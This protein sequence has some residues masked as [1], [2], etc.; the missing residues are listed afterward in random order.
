[1][2]DNGDPILNVIQLTL[3][4]HKVIGTVQ[5]EILSH[6]NRLTSLNNV[7]QIVL[8]ETLGIAIR[9]RPFTH[10]KIKL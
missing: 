5:M 4:M 8:L 7:K 3:L 2:M 1:L 9:E 6:H 10:L